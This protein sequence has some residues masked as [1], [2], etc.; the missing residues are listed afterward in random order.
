M[1]RKEGYEKFPHLS[2]V[3]SAS[4]LTDWIILEYLY[5]VYRLPSRCLQQ[6]FGYPLLKDDFLEISAILTSIS[7]YQTLLSM[8]KFMLRSRKKREAGTENSSQLL[9]VLASGHKHESHA[10]ES[11]QERK[12]LVNLIVYKK[13]RKQYEDTWFP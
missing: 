9:L 12:T 10:N 6:V 11:S 2:Y 13:I 5:T 1:Y 4:R 7:S 3:I 8:L